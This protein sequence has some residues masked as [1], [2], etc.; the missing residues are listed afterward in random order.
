MPTADSSVRPKRSTARSLPTGGCQPV[1]DD[2]ISGTFSIGQPAVVDRHRTPG[3]AKSD[4]AKL[5]VEW[6]RQ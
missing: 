4:I 5:D 6:S 3:A 2:A 1:E